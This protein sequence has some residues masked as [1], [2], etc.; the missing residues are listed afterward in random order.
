MFKRIILTDFADHEI[1]NGV[2]PHP[3]L[4]IK[5]EIHLPSSYSKFA[6]KQMFVMTIMLCS[7]SH[8]DE[9]KR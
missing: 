7:Q 8:R 1:L 9:R 4:V 3:L 6:N 5:A 2:V